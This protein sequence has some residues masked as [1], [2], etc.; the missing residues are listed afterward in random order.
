MLKSRKPIRFQ[1]VFQAMKFIDT[2]PALAERIRMLPSSREA[3]RVAGQNRAKQRED[4]FEVNIQKMDE[5][6]ALKFAPGTALAKMLEQTGDKEL[7]ED[8]PVSFE[9]PRLL[10]ECSLRGQG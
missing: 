1:S 4:W 8:S 10:F 9:E 7:I 6:L 3:L 2:H 5:V